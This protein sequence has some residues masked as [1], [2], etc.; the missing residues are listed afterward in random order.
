MTQFSDMRVVETDVLVLGGGLA[1]HRAAVAARKS[2]ASVALAYHARGASPHIIGFNVPL[3]DA[4]RRDCPDA[5]YE[6]MVRGG[7][8]LNERRLVRALADGAKAALAELVAIGVPFAQSGDKF[9]QRHLSGNTYARSVF[10][11]NGIGRLALERLIGHCKEIGVQAYSG[12]RAVALLRDRAEVLGA[13]LVKRNAPELL[14]IHAGATVLATGGI[15]AIYSDSTY[16]SDVAAD[17][18][19]FAL[20]AGA[21]LIDMEFVQ[22]EPTVVVHPEGC[23]GMEMPTAMFGDGARLLNAG[24]ERFMFRYNPG[25]GEMQ[26]EKARMSLCIQREIDA[27]RG[28][29]DQSVLFD[30]TGIASDR[31]ESYV[32]HCKRLRAAGLDPARSAPHVRPAA[33]SHMGG[34]LIDQHAFTGV[35]GLYAAGEA[36]GGVHGASRIAGN[37]ASDVIVFGG[38]A[39]RSAAA[40]RVDIAGRQWQRVHEQALEG[41]RRVEGRTGR[42]RPDKVRPALGEI[43]LEGAGIYRNEGALGRAAARLDDLQQRMNEDMAVEGLGEAVRALQAANM[44]LV[45]NIIVAAARARRE[46]RGA[47]QRTDFTACDDANWLRHTGVS[48][49][50]GAA[51]VLEAVPIR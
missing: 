11:P 39:G 26:I 25:H 46:S 41:L 1:G 48:M 47:H 51:I 38:I 50:T 31:L 2:G 29:L 17:S 40:Q 28:L 44:V 30:T 43:L 16:P 6:D 13:L 12:W 9:A 15:G 8:A 24:G 37:G 49:D 5:Y 42:L 21:T 3:G 36:A 19:A 23:K 34:V 14:A 22:F 7:Y 45:G 33:H 10:H 4:D 35:P 27:G 20:D 32:S 18:Y